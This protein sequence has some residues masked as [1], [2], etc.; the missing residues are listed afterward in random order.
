[1]SNAVFPTLPGLSWGSTKEPMW[2]TSAK[3]S[4]SG[5]EQR[6]GYMS[7]PLYRIRLSYEFLR[8]GAEAELQTLVGFFNQRGGDLESFL[9]LDPSDSSVTE[10]QFGVGDGTTTV[11]RLG[12]TLGGAYEPVSAINGTPVIAQSHNYLLYSEQIDNAA[13][14]KSVATTVAGNQTAAPN[15]TGTGDRVTSPQDA[16][17]Y[18]SVAV[19]SGTVFTVSAYVKFISTTSL[20]FRDSAGSTGHHVDIN[21]STGAIS[22]ASNVIASG[23]INAGS[24]WWRV[25]MTY[26]TDT[27]SITLIARPNN[28]G[29]TVFD[30]WGAQVEKSDQLGDYFATT[31]PNKP[32]SSYT[33]DPNTALV[34]Y[35]PAPA[36]GTLLKWA[37]SHYRRVRFEKSNLEFKE[38]LRDLWE[39]KSVALLTVK[40]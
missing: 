34:T 31:T 37:G 20:R 39:S 38:F 40:T 15:G 18:Q 19:T 5:M 27:T 8:A 22:N 21:L 16:G 23:S 24:G 13:W 7:Y 11:F 12:R 6:A 32:A 10:Q 14:T 1:M 29:T 33:L 17:V 28:A 2:T 35:T 36:S 25:W 26:T 9:W 4:A 3:R 30:L